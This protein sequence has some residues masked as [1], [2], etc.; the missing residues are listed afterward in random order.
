MAADA[1]P[2]PAYYTALLR[3]PFADELSLE[4]ARAAIDGEQ[5]GADHVPD[6]LAVSLSGHDY[7]N[8]AYSAES[9]LS[10]DHFLHLDRML[11]AFFAR[12]DATVGK[13][14]YLIALSADHGFTP[15]PPYL[16]SRG[17]DGE[18][19]AWGD[20]LVPGGKHMANTWQGSFPV[21]NLGEDGYERTSPVASFPPNDYGLYDMIGNV[22]EWTND[23]WSTGHAADAPK[24]CCVPLNPRGG[25][26]EASLDPRLPAIKI[27]RKVLKGGSH[28]CA[29]NYCRRYRPA[30]RHAE[31]IDTS[32]SHVGFRCVQ[33]T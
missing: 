7:V 19:F 16:A 21:E 9:R 31:P 15:A 25:N 24:A 33:R 18:E 30:A 2:G 5:L 26:K 23:W 4:F 6:I 17:R 8:H 11:A 14:R 10:H 13:D 1:A 3:S 20:E 32:T 29:P 28:L 22:W 12:L 27:P